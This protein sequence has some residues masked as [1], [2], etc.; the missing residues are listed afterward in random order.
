MRSRGER[1]LGSYL[2]NIG[3]VLDLYLPLYNKHTGNPV[4]YE[5]EVTDR[6]GD[7]SFLIR[8]QDGTLIKLGVTQVHEHLTNKAPKPKDPGGIM[9]GYLNVQYKGPRCS[10]QTSI[11]R[12]GNGLPF[13]NEREALE[14]MSQ[15]QLTLFGD[16]IYLCKITPVKVFF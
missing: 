10:Y 4:T 2:A 12:K 11:T 14:A 9:S 7:T 15:R 5:G 1:T 6:Q 8:A 13:D 16:P 3:R